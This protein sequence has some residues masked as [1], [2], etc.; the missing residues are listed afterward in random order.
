MNFLVTAIGPKGT[1]WSSII[2]GSGWLRKRFSEGGQAQELAPQ[3]SGHGT[4]PAVIQ[5][6]FGQHSQTYS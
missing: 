6:V 1:A 5:E 2:G 3:G 4:K